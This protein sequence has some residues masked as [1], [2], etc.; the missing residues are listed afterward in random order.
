MDQLHDT[1]CDACKKLLIIYK[2]TNL[3][4]GVLVIYLSDF[5]IMG[6]CDKQGFPMKQ[7]VL[8]PGR[9]GN[10][11]VRGTLCFRG[12]GRR[13]GELRRKSGHWCIVSQDISVLNLVIV[14]KG[15]NDLPGPM[16]RSQE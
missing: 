2:Q 13:N 11:L 1:E 6:E 14:K 4:Q 3:K 5:K 12:Y 9:V 8:A 10:I 15:D 16:L 7:G